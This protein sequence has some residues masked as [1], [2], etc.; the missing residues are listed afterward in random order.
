MGLSGPGRG[1]TDTEFQLVWEAREAALLNEPEMPCGSFLEPAVG[2]GEV[3]QKT[4]VINHYHKTGV[5][6]QRRSHTDSSSNGGCWYG[7]YTAPG[8][9]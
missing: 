5:E 9:D 7:M 6:L 1:K 8:T 4:H 2:L 3:S